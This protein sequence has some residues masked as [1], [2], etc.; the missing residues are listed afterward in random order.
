MRR[1]SHFEVRCILQH[2]LGQQAV[3]CALCRVMPRN[4]ATKLAYCYEKVVRG[5][6]YRK[7]YEIC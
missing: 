7:P 4:K 5:L 2:Y 3:F 1:V 6:L